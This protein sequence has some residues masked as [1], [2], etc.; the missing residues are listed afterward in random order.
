[1]KSAKLSPLHEILYIPLPPVYCLYF[2]FISMS[3]TLVCFVTDS[4]QQYIS[5]LFL[6]L[7]PKSVQYP[8]NPLYNL[9]YVYVSFSPAT[10]PP[11]LK[12]HESRTAV[13]MTTV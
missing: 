4:Q 12:N 1:M 11:L 6:K 8:L 7:N 9:L 13:I 3:L 10:H 5:Q 2:P